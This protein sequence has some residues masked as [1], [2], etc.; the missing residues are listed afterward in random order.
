M[1]LRGWGAGGEE[2]WK[3][4]QTLF[5][6][7]IMACWNQKH[8]TRTIAFEQILQNK[9]NVYCAILL[10]VFCFFFY[11]RNLREARDNAVSEKERAVIAEKDA[12][13]KYEQLLEQ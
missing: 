9:R 8:K 13:S 4:K 10:F 1:K 7:Q 11:F 2:R 5:Q 6:D 12:L 3:E